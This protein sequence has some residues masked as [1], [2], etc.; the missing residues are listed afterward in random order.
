MYLHAKAK[1]KNTPA[2]DSV[3]NINKAVLYYLNQHK[4]PTKNLSPAEFA[5]MIDLKFGTELSKFSVL[6]QKHKYNKTAVSIEEIEKMKNFYQ[7]F[8]TKV[9]S[10]ISLK[11]R[12]KNFF[13]FSNTLNFYSKSKIN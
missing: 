11:Q 9:K 6:Y 7:P 13:N 2:N 1:N 5:Y 10:G 3:Y 4:L 12:I 8:I